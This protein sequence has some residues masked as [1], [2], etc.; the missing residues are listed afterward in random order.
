MLFVAAPTW[1]DIDEGKNHNVYVSGL[2]L[3]ITKEEFV[4]MM[5]KCGIIM[6]DDEGRSI[7]SLKKG[8]TQNDMVILEHKITYKE[9][10][11]THLRFL[12]EPQ[13]LGTEGSLCWSESTSIYSAI[14]DIWGRGGWLYIFER[15]SS[16]W[17][18]S[19]FFFF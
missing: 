19:F 2:P 15:L 1:F 7:N 18:L 17:K 9:H 6:E 8:H 14:V 13:A 12:P 11:R 10:L 5:T 4:E 3:D 16:S